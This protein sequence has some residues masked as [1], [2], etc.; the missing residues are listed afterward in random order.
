MKLNPSTVLFREDYLR[1]VT[2]LFASSGLG[3]FTSSL[4]CNFTGATFPNIFS[5]VE[6]PQ[7]TPRNGFIL[8][9]NPGIGT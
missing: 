4:D 8:T 7:D 1:V 9:G 3:E 6:V 2:E 5:G